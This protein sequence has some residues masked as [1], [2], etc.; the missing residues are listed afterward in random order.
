MLDTPLSL[1]DVN[2]VISG[3]IDANRLNYI[4]KQAIAGDQVIFNMAI[5]NKVLIQWAS[6]K[7]DYINLLN[8][9]IPRNAVK[10]KKESQ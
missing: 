8:Y 3:G 6:E 5:K 9:A 1:G 10:I 4:A 7:E 2:I